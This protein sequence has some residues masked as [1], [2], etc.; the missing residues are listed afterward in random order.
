MPYPYASTKRCLPKEYYDVL[1]KTRPHW[2][3]IASTK[4]EE[5]NKRVD[6]TAHE[7]LKLKNIPVIWKD[8]LEYHTSQSFYEVIL[9]KFG[10]YFKQYYPKLDFKNMKAARRGS[11]AKADIYLDCQI[12]VNTPVKE[13]S[14]VSKPHLDHP[15]ELWAGL[16][17]M[18]DDD[19]NA[20]GDLLI[21]KCIG[22]PKFY[23]KRQVKDDNIAVVDTIPYAANTMACFMN[24]PMSVHA[25]SD[26][27]KTDKPRLFINLVLEFKQEEESLFEIKYEA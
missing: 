17:Y 27:E 19:D 2:V 5:N 14:T 4:K 15:Q 18:R 1:K 21:H 6:L 13:K 3:Q 8:F 16:L 26:R 25:V 22:V 12:S 11:G 10:E 23:D 7:A 24:S 9:K 20:G